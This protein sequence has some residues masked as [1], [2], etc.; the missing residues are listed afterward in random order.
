MINLDDFRSGLRALI[1]GQSEEEKRNFRII[2]I[3]IIVAILGGTVAMQYRNF[4]DYYFPGKDVPVK[5]VT[6]PSQTFN[7]VGKITK[8]EKGSMVLEGASAVKKININSATII[9]KLAFV[10]IMDN[11]KRR[12]VSQEKTID[13]AS[14]KV[15]WNVE[16]LAST[17]INKADEFDAVHV[18]VLP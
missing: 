7:F 18:R 6:A 11:G 4:L 3:L 1:E 2:G 16:A 10:P 8:I 13:A 12:F 5:Q 14:L 15:G 17:G 9:T